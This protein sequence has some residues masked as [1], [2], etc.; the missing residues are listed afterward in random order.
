MKKN[1]NKNEKK[2][3]YDAKE[4]YSI[5]LAV[6][7]IVISALLIPYHEI[8]RDEGQAWLIARDSSIFQLF[9]VLKHE[10]HPALWYLILMPFA[11]SGLPVVC[12]NYI[13]WFFN[14]LAIILI[15]LRSP[16]QPVTKTV[17]LVSPMFLYWLPVISRSYSP[18]NFLIIL[19]AL[20]YENRKKHPIVYG[21][22]LFLMINFHVII[23]GLVGAALL[24]GIYDVIQ[25]YKANRKVCKAEAA[26]I[27]IGIL[28]CLLMVLQLAGSPNTGNWDISIVFDPN[29]FTERICSTACTLF[30]TMS[31]T[32][33]KVLGGGVLIISFVI[34]LDLC[35]SREWKMMLYYALG[36]G[37]VWYILFFV[38]AGGNKM[39]ILLSVMIFILWCRKKNDKVNDKEDGKQGVWRK[40][41][42]ESLLVIVMIISGIGG[43]PNAI[44]NDIRESFSAGEQTAEYLQQ[45]Y[46]EGDVIIIIDNAY[47]AAV[48][49]HL[50]RDVKV[51]DIADGE[52]RK[53]PLWSTERSNA[54]YFME[55]LYAAQQIKV[56]ESGKNMNG[57]APVTGFMRD[58]INGVFPRGTIVYMVLN[59]EKYRLYDRESDGIGYCLLG[60]FYGDCRYTKEN[61]KVY[62]FASEGAE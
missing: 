16:F 52:F 40:K 61:F 45:V 3:E 35:F 1:E 18:L 51:W 14:V 30:S 11:K 50:D 46:K 37:F 13:S 47:E 59:E 6:L 15:A 53:F 57:E 60:E 36:I 38:L 10:G 39:Y 28:G 44:V 7:T 41:I 56:N 54:N 31:V 23:A 9:S 34:F 42:M 2:K 33:Q 22:V 21:I 49:A 48:T 62:G 26:G 17:F 58:Y 8:W 55:Y 4:V 32:Q 12:V 19:L 25:E 24:V 43:F 27:G 29:L 20:L 5:C